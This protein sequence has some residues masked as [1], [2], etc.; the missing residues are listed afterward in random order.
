MPRGDGT[1]PKGDG[2]RSGRGLGD[3]SGSIIKN[4]E[5]LSRMG[6]FQNRFLDRR[7]N[8]KRFRN[9]FQRNRFTK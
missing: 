4:T 7:R 2:P 9:F 1:G 5:H 6:Y 3:C 8:F